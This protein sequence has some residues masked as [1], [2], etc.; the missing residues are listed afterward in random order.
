MNV[1]IILIFL[2]GLS[3]VQLIP[4]PKTKQQ[5]TL[6]RFRMQFSKTVNSLKNLDVVIS[7]I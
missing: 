3:D 2:S 4:S 7:H 6:Q 1:Y 5:K